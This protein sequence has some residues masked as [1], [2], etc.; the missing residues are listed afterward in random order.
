V[1]GT[2]YQILAVKKKATAAE[3]KRAYRRLAK[4]AHPDVDKTSGAADRFMAIQEA[5]EVLSDPAKRAAYDV[6]LRAKK[7]SPAAAANPAP[8]APPRSTPPPSPPPAGA[9]GGGARPGSS[10]P[11]PKPPMPPQPAPPNWPLVFAAIGRVLWARARPYAIGIAIGLGIAAIVAVGSAMT[12][13]A[14][15]QTQD[16]R[17][18][19]PPPV[20]IA[21]ASAPKILSHVMEPNHRES[22]EQGTKMAQTSP[23]SDEKSPS[24]T[25]NGEVK[26][27]ENSVIDVAGDWKGSYDFE[28]F[29]IPF[30]MTLSEDRSRISGRSFE[31]DGDAHRDAIL[32]GWAGVGRLTIAKRYIA[33]GRGVCYTTTEVAPDSLSGRWDAMGYAGEWRAE[34]TPYPRPKKEWKTSTISRR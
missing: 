14:S 4:M 25:A 6:S 8:G 15:L 11:P 18:T 13:L 32:T 30:S 10:G 23:E 3:V 9:A 28:G 1:T 26:P 5:Y 12:V 33:R 20:A 31:F 19:A 2:H 21:G 24:E 16:A 29:T 27:H 7:T 17:S 34:R 22:P